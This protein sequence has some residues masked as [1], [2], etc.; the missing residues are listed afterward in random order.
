MSFLEL[1]FSGIMLPITALLLLVLC[2]WCAVLIGAVGLDLFDVEI[3][4][5]VSS[6]LDGGV[7]HGE[8]S[9]GTVISALKF[10]HLGEVPFMLLISVF[11][12]CWWVATGIGA[13]YFA[14][15]FTGI[16]ALIWIGPSFLVGLL[17]T[18]G[19]LLPTSRFFR[20]L[21]GSRHAEINL[22]GR[23]CAVTSSEV[24]DKFG[25]AQV[26]IDGPPIII[27]VRA[28]NGE[29]FRKGDFAQVVEFNEVTRTYLIRPIASSESKT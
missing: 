3:E 17:M 4:T 14:E 29:V 18:K 15:R 20:A 26:E 16:W 5:E 7:S 28:E 22:V 8:N 27:D 19:L 24:T 13:A 21:D 12:L 9:G 6:D 11:T 25:L 10:F 23:T 1:I 2:Y